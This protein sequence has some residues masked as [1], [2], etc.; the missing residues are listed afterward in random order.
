MERTAA[1]EMD[2]FAQILV[3]NT[4]EYIRSRFVIEESDVK[5]DCRCKLCD[6]GG[7]KRIVY[8]GTLCLA[9]RG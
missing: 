5:K 9:F 6:S 2:Y 7:E 8:Q 4:F 3:R 1:M